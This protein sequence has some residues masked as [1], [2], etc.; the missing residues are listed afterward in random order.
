MSLRFVRLL[1]NRSIKPPA[2]LAAGRQSKIK[3]L[4]RHFPMSVDIQT[5]LG[6]EAESLLGFNSPKISKDMLQLPGPDYIDRV[7]SATDRTPV[8]LRNF[9][10]LFNAGGLAGS[11]YVSFLPVDQGIEHGRQYDWPVDKQPHEARRY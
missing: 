5:L 3:S 8:L 9:Q 10:S 11:G 1:V 6:A 2:V 4:R 7:F